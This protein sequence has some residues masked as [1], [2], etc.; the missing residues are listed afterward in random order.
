MKPHL[1]KCNARP[2][3]NPS[4]FCKDINLTLQPEEVPTAA[5]GVDLLG[6][7]SHE[8]LA[9]LIQK[10]RDLHAKY[11]PEIRTS[12]LSHSALDERK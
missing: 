8:K 1:Y 2:K 7:L 3:E 11:V 10:I 9:E 6:K 5:T 4:L 12:I